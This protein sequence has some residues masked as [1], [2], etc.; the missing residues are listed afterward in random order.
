MRL[1]PEDKQHLGTLGNLSSGPGATTR[2]RQHAKQAHSTPTDT[3]DS[4]LSGPSR[5]RHH[6]EQAGSWLNFVVCLKAQRQCMEAEIEGLTR[7]NSG[8]NKLGKPLS[9]FNGM[10]E[11]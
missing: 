3:P 4:S 6:S 8:T 2:G 9:P 7:W 1:L 5:P 11:E 10:T